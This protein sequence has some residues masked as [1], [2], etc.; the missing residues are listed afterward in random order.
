M[1]AF[2]PDKKIISQCMLVIYFQKTVFSILF[3]IYYSL[4]KSCTQSILESLEINKAV[5]KGIALNILVI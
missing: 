3:L 4:N 2:K 1:L 5:N